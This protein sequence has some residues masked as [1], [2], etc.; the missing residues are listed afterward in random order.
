MRNTIK[1]TTALTLG[2]IFTIQADKVHAMDIDEMKIC[3]S[4]AELAK[5]P[6]LTEHYKA[7]LSLNGVSGPIQNEFKSIVKAFYHG[8]TSLYL[9]TLNHCIV[10]QTG[11][12]VGKKVQF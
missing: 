6:D 12:M 11:D 9:Q 10:N 3:K 4:V 1:I 8:D 7:R 2:L 5:E